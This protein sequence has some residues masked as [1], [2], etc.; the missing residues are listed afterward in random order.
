[1]RTD[2]ASPDRSPPTSAS[3]GHRAFA[4]WLLL[5]AGLVWV[6]V[7]LGGATRLTGSG[8]SIM[9]WAPIAGILPPLSNAE[10]T[11]LYDLYRSIPQYELV[12]QGFGIE[13]FK[14]IFWLEWIHRFWG[15]LLGLVYGGGLIWFWLRAGIPAD[16]RPRLLLMLALGAMQGVIGW[17]MVAS[18]FEADRT[19]VSPYRLVLHLGLAL[20]LYGMLLWT[21]LDTL[22]PKAAP[23]AGG[24]EARLRAGLRLAVALAFATML[25]GGFVAGTRAGFD[26]NTFPLMD[27]AIVPDG[28]WRPAL[29]WRNATENIAAVQLNHRM[30]AGI[31]L[32]LA[33]W[34]AWRAMRRTTR[35]G[36][37]G[38]ILGFSA[39]VAL[40]YGLGVA[41]LLAVVPIWLGTLHQAIAVLVVTT[42][43]LA[44]HHL[45]N[46][47]R[48]PPV[49]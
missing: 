33:G 8:L 31:T 2:V 13:G 29:G 10:W 7:A 17:F 35:R 38:A 21:A 9:E 1:M 14:R 28:Y 23:A 3:P 34:L 4:L 32:L 45:R 46:G 44:L 26:Y 24:A 19:T 41:T 16:L 11:R 30:L 18:G 20:V 39:S 49:P 48:G 47:A 43:L 6:M 5:V 27:G 12:N 22:N 42:A 37:R 15:R 40:Q 25:A 36:L